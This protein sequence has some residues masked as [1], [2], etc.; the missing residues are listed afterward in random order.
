M[1]PRLDD[2]LPLAHRTRSVLVRHGEVAALASLAAAQ[3]AGRPLSAV[4][5]GGRVE[6]QVPGLVAGPALEVAPGLRLV[7]AEASAPGRA[8][9]RPRAATR[10]IGLLRPVARRTAAGRQVWAWVRRRLRKS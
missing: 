4:L 7:P 6:L 5:L 9:V 3:H 8:A 10:L 1:P 2:R